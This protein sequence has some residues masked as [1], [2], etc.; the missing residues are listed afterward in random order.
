M[1]HTLRITILAFTFLLF[2][3]VLYAQPT[4]NFTVNRTAGCEPL[5]VVFTDQSTVPNSSISSWRWEANGN[6]FSSS[7]DPTYLIND[8][9]R[10]TI[11]LTVTDQNGASN[12]TCKDDY[13]EVYR[14]PTASYTA[15]RR[16][17]CAPLEVNLRSTS[18]TN[19]GSISSWVWDLGGPCGVIPGT[20]SDQVSC[21]Y[22]LAG[23]YQPTLIVT[24][25]RGC[26]NSV[27]V[28]DFI[29][30]I[31]DPDIQISAATT[32]ACDPPFNVSFS[33]DNPEPGTTYRWD[34]GNATTY[35]GT[36][37]PTVTYTEPGRY[38]LSV[39]ATNA[40]GCTQTL[41]LDDY[42]QIGYEVDFSF[43]SDAGCGDLNVNFFDN[44]P[45]GATSILFDFGDGSTST[46][47]NASHTYAGTGC[48]D[49]TL[50]R[51]VDGC[52]NSFTRLLCITDPQDINVTADVQNRLGCE[53]PHTVNF[54][55]VSPV[56]ESWL[57]DFGDGTTS[58]E[59]SPT[60]V[61][62]N[63]G[64]Y[65]IRLTV[66]DA[67]GCEKTVTTQNVL[68]RPLKVFVAQSSVNEGCLPLNFT[69][70]DS[71]FTVSPIVAC[72]WRVVD[73]SDNVIFSST[74]PQP[75]GILDRE[76]CFHIE[77]E[78]ENSLGCRETNLF[79]SALCAGNQPSVDFS[80]APQTVCASDEVNFTDLSDDSVTSWAWDLDGDGAFDS[81]ESNPE[82]TYRDTGCFDVTL[83][84]ASFG[85]TNQVTF[86]DYIC[87]SPPVAKFRT[88]LDC[89]T[90]FD[91]TFT[92]QSIGADSVFWDFGVPT[93]L[94]DTSSA[95]NTSFTFPSKDTYEVTMI[96]Y[97]FDQGCT[98]TIRG[99]VIVTEL[100]ANFTLATDQGCAPM[101]LEIDNN[102]V[103]A[104]RYDWTAPG[105]DISS[106]RATRPTIIF[107]NPG[108]YEVELIARDVNNCRD[109]FVYQNIFANE[110]EVN[111]TT[112]QLNDCLPVDVQLTDQST[113]LYST[114]VQWEWIFGEIGDTVG[115]A[116]GDD[117]IYTFDQAGF[118]PTQLVVTDAWGCVD[119]LRLYEGINV[120]APFA[121]FEVDSFSCPGLDL[122]FLN[123]SGGGNL[124]YEWDFGDGSM[125]TAD[126]NPTHE[127]PL[128]VYTASLTITSAS[129][130]NTTTREIT[131]EEVLSNFAIDPDFPPCPP[132]TVNFDNF[133]AN[134]REFI[135]LFGDN[136]GSSDQPSHIYNEKGF[137]DV[138]LVAIGANPGC[139]DT[140]ALD[141]LVVIQ[142]PSGDFS[143]TVDNT[144]VPAEV[145]FIGQS[146]RPY[147]YTWFLDDGNTL[148]A[149][150][151]LR[152]TF[153]YVYNDVAPDGYL[154]KLMLASTC[155]TVLVS[156]DTIFL[157]DLT[158]DFAASDTFLCDG[159]R[160][161]A[162]ESL[163]ETNAPDFQATWQLPGA[164]PATSTQADVA[165]EYL[166]PGIY[167]VSLSV[168]SGDCE[169]ELSKSALVEVV[170]F[171]SLV[172]QD[173]LVCQGDTVQFDIST[174]ATEF[175]WTPDE[176][177]SDPT[178]A[179][180]TLV[181]TRSTD[182]VVAGTYRSC[183][184][185]FDTLRVDVLPSPRV[186]YAPV[187]RFFPG[188][189]LLLEVRP[190]NEVEQYA[191]D[192]FPRTGLSC[193]DC[194]NPSVTPD[195]SIVYSIVVTNVESGCVSEIT[196]QVR[197]LTSCPED[198]IY[199]P[200]IFSPN[201]DGFN[202]DFRVLSTNIMESD[203]LRV[204]DRW[205]ALVWESSDINEGWDGTY[206]GQPAGPGVYVYSLEA[207]CILD[208][209]TIR[210]MGDVTIV[211]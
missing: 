86:D 90:P 52:T 176:L 174:N 177:L 144:C 94:N 29:T 111:F 70:T 32:F 72:N 63:F 158:I 211:R 46:F 54:T 16:E 19:N 71:V 101:E 74:D 186:I 22:T 141:S 68:I 83:L 36:L 10:Y 15:D 96:A 131:V 25:S 92:N 159:E 120:N 198:L 124:T 82:Y 164:N 118:I 37:P 108:E 166:D 143:F 41:V 4:A 14:K 162:F 146:D 31:P 61:Y 163:V 161:V 50:T 149:A 13:I 185:A 151:A 79:P 95:F 210:K 27:S 99:E 160:M 48:Y 112:Q 7:E 47:G 55:G 28:E 5:T 97:N 175:S 137:F 192:W 142:G 201:G 85:C 167:D 183:N 184:T 168:R 128:G 18:S 49:V 113:N 152:D 138:T 84:V 62:Q 38:T 206:R 6:F 173:E 30:V 182:F 187:R 139:R 170:D 134:A 109:T 75:S 93:S 178:V 9:G 65:P 191:Y 171:V 194:P 188:Q 122:S 114:N 58:T 60:H 189:T 169:A 43:N 69:L 147:T 57:W 2:Q 199:A 21:T 156:P 126:E 67:F 130:V 200:N 193:N 155:D 202:D 121:A 116:V 87:I 140:L 172:A 150:D 77:L 180:P 181:P 132:S 1:L 154:P 45:D 24:D 106:R 89:V 102:S 207:P 127:Y 179:D 190:E 117:L 80:G 197:E 135:W 20:A 119:S 208:D 129:C 115:T 42:I 145:T 204:F 11:C 78:V 195:S 23:S 26:E 105:G 81:S 59:P 196:M 209:T 91:R 64:N 51:T 17:G 110:I 125:T 8:P 148:L 35:E 44:S 66:T 157:T 123:Q 107:E 3:G 56:A 100:E 33:N 40:S 88:R 153:T 104:S 34:L 133:S 53:L 103:D 76:G 73:D 203:F 98:D 205:G 12:R 136:T 165:T 39:E